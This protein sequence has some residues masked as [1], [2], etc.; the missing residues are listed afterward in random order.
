MQEYS[1][2]L[3]KFYTKELQQDK[4]LFGG[5]VHE[6]ILVPRGTSI[7]SYMAMDGL[8]GC[9]IRVLFIL[10]VRVPV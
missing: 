9:I 6:W 10:L 3:L 8:L 2:I 1:K 4:E 5:L 7:H